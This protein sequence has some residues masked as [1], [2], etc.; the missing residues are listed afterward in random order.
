MTGSTDPMGDLATPSVDASNGDGVQIGVDI[1][2][3]STSVALIGSDYRVIARANGDT[4]AAVGPEAVLN[5][6]GELIHHLLGRVW[7]DT[8]E[9]SRNGGDDHA[10]ADYVIGVGTTGIIDPGTGVIRASTSAM[11]GW[12]GTDVVGGLQARLGSTRVHALNDVH[13]FALGEGVA[14]AAQRYRSFLA[15][16]LGTGIGGAVVA[17]G[18]LLLGRHAAAGH[19][20]HITVP[21]AAGVRCPCGALGHLEGIGGAPAVLARAQAAGVVSRD[22]KGLFDA[23]KVGDREA[24]AQVEGLACAIGTAIADITATVAPD[25]VVVGGG[26]AR[27]GDVL[28]NRVRE[29]F[30]ESVLPLFADVPIVTSQLDA[31]AVMIGAVAGVPAARGGHA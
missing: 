6:V 15:I 10:D 8:E 4:P 26:L 9:S 11:P 21:Q 25:I 5:R 17:D 1:G 22:V 7:P 16:T 30:A 13:A 23:A 2:G 12:Q 27:A 19:V 3:T 28:M 31:D 18:Q 29:S 14:G 24:R 20:G